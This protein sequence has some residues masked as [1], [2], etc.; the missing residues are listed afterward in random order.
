MIDIICR[1]LS[2]LW[3]LVETELM[4]AKGITTLRLW[5]LNKQLYYKRYASRQ[6]NYGMG[7]VSLKRFD[8]LKGPLMR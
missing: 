3:E 2:S 7:L 5:E 1:N 8:R 4:A 6:R